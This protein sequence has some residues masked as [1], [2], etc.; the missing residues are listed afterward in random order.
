MDKTNRESQK[1]T[2]T[3]NLS[4]NKKWAGDIG[5]FF[6]KRVNVLWRM[7]LSKQNCI[8]FAYR[9]HVKR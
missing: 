2:L 1:E 5:P 6:I 8:L 7:F 3:N 9:F 4:R